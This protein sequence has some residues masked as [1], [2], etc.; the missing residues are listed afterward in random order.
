MLFCTRLGKKLGLTRKKNT[1]LQKR[2]RIIK[3]GFSRRDRWDP[4]WILG[5]HGWE[6]NRY[7]LGSTHGGSSRELSGHGED[8]WTAISSGKLCGGS[9]G[10]AHY[11]P[12][13]LCLYL[14]HPFVRNLGQGVFTSR[15]RAWTGCGV[16]SHQVS[17][18]Q[19]HPRAYRTNGMP[20]SLLASWL[21]RRPSNKL[22]EA[23][24]LI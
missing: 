12:Y 14:Y 4:I 7:V 15:T 16:G 24:S 11:F 20:T 13:D 21:S 23:N 10:Q 1:P 18:V 22:W 2:N 19:A 9:S 17:Q 3:K 5:L 6:W 8:L